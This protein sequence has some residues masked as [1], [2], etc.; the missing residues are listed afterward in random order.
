MPLHQ[1]KKGEYFWYKGKL[2]V[3]PNVDEDVEHL[4]EITQGSYSHVVVILLEEN[5]IRLLPDYNVMVVP[6]AVPLKLVLGEETS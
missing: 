2:Y 5:R 6:E 3:Y 1:I 4:L